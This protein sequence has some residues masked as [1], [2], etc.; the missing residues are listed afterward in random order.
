VTVAEL[1]RLL[2]DLGKF[3]QSA[4][5]ATVARELDEIS[6]KLQPFRDYTLK[7]FGDFL[8]KAE[9]YSRGVLLPKKTLAGRKPK[10]DP[11]AVDAACRQ[12]LQVYERAID[13]SVTVEQIESAVQSLQDQDP[14]KGRLDEL[15][16]KMD[17]VQKFRS[18]A[19][20]LKAIRQ[21]I[22]GRKGAYDRVHA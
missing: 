1:Q 7:A 21:K 8:V 13:P 22:L 16:Q 11:G 15:A 18:K 3:L 9:E 4:K 6:G 12:V 5:A 14:P 17:F 19:E 20:V 10:K 2:S